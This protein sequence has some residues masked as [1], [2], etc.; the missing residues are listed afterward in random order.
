M[1]L[2]TVLIVTVSAAFAQKNVLKDERDIPLRFSR[3]GD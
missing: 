1:K 2:T 3:S